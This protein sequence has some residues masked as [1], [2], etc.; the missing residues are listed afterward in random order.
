MTALLVCAALLA[1]LGGVG[2]RWRG[3]APGVRSAADAA[4]PELVTATAANIDRLERRV[5]RTELLV[6]RMEQTAARFERWM[7]C[8]SWVPVTEYGDP[9]QQF[10][11]AY[12]EMD[13]TGP[14]FRRVLA[15]DP[16]PKRPDYI[17][18]DFAKRD[19]CRSAPTRPGTAENPGTADNAAFEASP[20]VESPA[21]KV[22]RLQRKL[23]E[24]T[25]RAAKLDAMSERFD[26]WE[27]CLSWVPVTEYGDS[28]GRYGY[29]FTG[30]NAEAG[31][32]FMPA[33]AIDISEWDDPDFMLLAFA[34]LDRPF[35]ERECD[36]EPGESV[37]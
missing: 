5:R 30:R 19:E 22:S 11:Y 4:H 18:I 23:A 36:D 25:A 16:H 6:E 27:S 29:V 35:S 28:E 1:V 8:I 24:L 32:G 17:F 34:G 9:D 31:Q 3:T 10:G 13:G 2:L 14:E 15:V 12:N 26:E 33:L 7:A 21:D 20:P 37:D